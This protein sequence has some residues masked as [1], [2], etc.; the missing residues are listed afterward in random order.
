MR[1]WDQGAQ[2]ER[3][4][5]A[6]SRT[7]LSLVGVGLACVKLAPSL[8]G[9]VLAAAVVCGAL[10]LRLL[11]IGPHRRERFERLTQG[12]SVADPAS[13]LLATAITVLMAVVGLVFALS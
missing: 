11:R 4:S 6:W 3:T 7:T 1:L 5:L 12:R 2:P 13:V 9:A 10:A 8:L